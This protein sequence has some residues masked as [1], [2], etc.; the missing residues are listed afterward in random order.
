MNYGDIKR[1]IMSLADLEDSEMDDFGNRVPDSINRAISE[2]GL[3]R[4]PIY[5]SYEIEIDETD[6]DF[7]YI[8]MASRKGFLD[9][10]DTPVMIAKDG[11]EM[12]QAFNNFEIQM[13]TVI[14]IDPKDNAG[15]Y[16]IFYKK[17]HSKFTVE[18]EDD[19]EVE[20]RSIVQP[21]I[22]PLAAYYLLLPEDAS[23]ATQIYNKA[24]ELF[25]GTV[26][27]NKRPKVGVKG[28]WEI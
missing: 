5:G 8:D 12:Y 15:T 19:A 3:L 23:I 26:A 24:T 25:E 22:A 7:I 10:A 4:E 2:I 6:E 14:V 28:G 18:S 21:L 11:K 27:R 9:F 13:G 1:E 20:V 17:E 16:K